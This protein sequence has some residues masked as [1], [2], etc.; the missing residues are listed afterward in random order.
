MEK[1]RPLLHQEALRKKGSVKDIK[2]DPPSQR[3]GKDE[4]YLF[5]GFFNSRLRA[6]RE[7]CRR[8]VLALV[9]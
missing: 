2:C 4:C 7:A 8:C 1:Y 5:S 9:D 3:E 6:K